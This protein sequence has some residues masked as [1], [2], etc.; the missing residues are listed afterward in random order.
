[1]LS[2]ER[3]TENDRIASAGEQLP[4][5]HVD[6]DEWREYQMTFIEI[7]GARPSYR[8]EEKRR[9]GKDKTQLT[10][11]CSFTPPSLDLPAKLA[12]EGACITQ[13][14]AVRPGANDAR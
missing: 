14:G 12:G 3:N 5:P 9:L 6:W 4:R 8:V 11:S 13:I 10:I 2:Q 1:M 7:E